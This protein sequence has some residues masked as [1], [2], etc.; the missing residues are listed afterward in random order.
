[1]I[2]FWESAY[3][4]YRRPLEE[5]V[6]FYVPQFPVPLLSPQFLTG[7]RAL[8][9]ERNRGLIEYFNEIVP[10]GHDQRGPAPAGYRL[11]KQFFLGERRIAAR[12]L[13]AGFSVR[14]VPLADAI[15]GEALRGLLADGFPRD[16]AF[17]RVLL[18]F[19]AGLDA[20]FRTLFLREGERD[21]GAVS[22]GVAGGVALVLNAVIPSSDRGRRLSPVLTDA[23]Q[24]LAVSLGAT[25]AF[26]WTEHPFLGRHADCLW[27]YRIFSRLSG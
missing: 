21:V 4:R 26:F 24:T 15:E 2:R 3:A 1:M 20:E 8:F 14:V 11:E 13:P 18:P 22:V 19:L 12:E 5:G 17:L 25:E 16:A 7:N 6:G 27:H 10:L 23:S 9:L